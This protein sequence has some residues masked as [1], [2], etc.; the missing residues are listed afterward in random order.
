MRS[1]ANR[2][3]Q[4]SADGTDQGLQREV[5]VEREVLDDAFSVFDRCD[6]DV[7]ELH[8]KVG[9]ERDVAVVSVD[10]ELASR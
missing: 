10:D 4:C 9:Q 6:E 8:M 3:R 1:V 5:V 7:A 2:Q